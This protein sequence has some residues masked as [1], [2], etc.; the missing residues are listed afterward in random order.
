MKGGIFRNTITSSSAEVIGCVIG[1]FL[2][3]GQPSERRVRFSLALVYF[4]M[5]AG[6][7]SV[8]T[9]DIYGAQNGKWI[10]C[11]VLL[12]NMGIG[13]SYVLQSGII[14]FLFDA[15]YQVQ[16]FSIANFIAV[17]ISAVSPLATEL[18]D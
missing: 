2:L 1:G 6:S 15:A 16:V 7:I 9:C 8:L 11:F 12:I 13:A 17:F 4:S 5:L 18:L 3:I 10:P 14:P